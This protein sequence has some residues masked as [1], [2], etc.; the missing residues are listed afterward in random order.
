VWYGIACYGI[1]SVQ[2]K[3]KL[4]RLISTAFRIVGYQ[5]PC[6]LQSLYEKSVLRE[7]LKIRD[8]P[9]H[10]LNKELELLLK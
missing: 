8:D 2:L 1:L 3:S 9:T 10:I 4:G 6:Y 7:A 5:E